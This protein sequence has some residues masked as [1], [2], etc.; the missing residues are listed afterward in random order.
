MVD[1]YIRAAMTHALIELVDDAVAAT[2]PEAFGV[3]AFG[4]TKQDCLDD[5]YARLEEWVCAGVA[6][7]EELPIIEGIEFSFAD[8]RALAA[9]HAPSRTTTDSDFFENE[10][11]FEAALSRWEQEE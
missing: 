2:V 7:G 1:A 5:L 11:E 10:Q 3:V 6:N 8:R 9:Y 4:A